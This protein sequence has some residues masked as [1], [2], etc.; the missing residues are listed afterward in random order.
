MTLLSIQEE[1]ETA[2]GWETVVRID[3][4]P[5]DHVTVSK[6]FSEQEEKELEWYFEE[7]LT[8]PFTQNVRAQQAAASIAT[9][10]ETLFKQV[11]S[12]PD[13]YADYRNMRDSGLSN[14]RIEIEGS[15]KFHA[16][17]WEAL[18]DPKLS[19]PLALQAIIIRK[20]VSRQTIPASLRQSPII[21]LL[22]VTARPAGKRDVGYRT[23]SRPLVGALN[24]MG[25]AI[26][27][28]CILM[29]MVLSSRMSNCNEGKR[30]AT[31]SLK[32]VCTR[33]PA[34]I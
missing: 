15:P 33:R 1:A 10:G 19:Q 34:V 4:G 30:P 14:L 27:T 21:N 20:N 6:P 31:L 3:S 9:Y 28:S 13:I 17:H 2:S 7:H 24:S 32:A 29:C 22:I 26:T 5:Q 11:F 23:I 12:T 25:R 16:L 8:F 18:K